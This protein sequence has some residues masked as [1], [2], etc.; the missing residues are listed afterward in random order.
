MDISTIAKTAEQ[1]VSTLDGALENKPTGLSRLLLAYAPQIV[2]DFLV[3]GRLRLQQLRHH[4]EAFEE[5]FKIMQDTRRKLIESSVSKESNTPLL[6]VQLD[7]LEKEYRLLKT[8]KMALL[9]ADTDRGIVDDSASESEAV[10]WDMFE[11]LASRR[12]EAWRVNLFARIIAENDKYPGAISLKAL[13]EIAMMETSD[14]VSLSVFCDSSLYIDGK[15]VVLMDPDEQY[16]YESEINNSYTGNL[17][18]CI[19]SLIDKNL[20]QKVSTQFMT[21]EPVE[22]NHKSDVTFLHHSVLDIPKHSETAIRIDGY[23]PTDHCLEI[24]RLYAP[25]LNIASDRNFELLQE[26]LNEQMA[27]SDNEGYQNKFEFVKNSG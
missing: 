6:R 16:Q 21:S 9:Y 24:C 25:N 19:T 11:D 10:W 23:S 2:R 20:I 14:F 22:L 27:K 7:Q 12:N 15:P 26:Q 4:E 1:A 5:T 8:V 3:A 18:L 13:W 17:A